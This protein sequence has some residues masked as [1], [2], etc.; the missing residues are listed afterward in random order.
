M[1]TSTPVNRALEQR[2]SRSTENVKHCPAGA[3]PDGVLSVQLGSDWGRIPPWETLAVFSRLFW[4][5]WERGCS[6]CPLNYNK[7][8]PEDVCCCSHTPLHSPFKKT[9]PLFATV[10]S[11]RR[12]GKFCCHFRNICTCYFTLL[13]LSWLMLALLQQIQSFPSPLQPQLTR[14]LCERAASNMVSHIFSGAL[15]GTRAH[16][17]IFSAWIQLFPASSHLPFFHSG[18]DPELAARKSAR[19]PSPA[20][21]NGSPF[22]GALW[23]S[24]GSLV[25]MAGLQEKGRKKKE[26][27]SKRGK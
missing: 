12:E 15:W 21:N 16:I 27:S 22:S 5:I 11:H 6:L 17:S 4:S 20:V 14:T 19:S 18:V 8:L 2:H 10:T 1:A 7:P 13:G 24:A 9:V 23:E 25:Q 3:S 26:E